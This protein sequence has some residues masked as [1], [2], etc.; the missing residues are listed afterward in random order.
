MNMQKEH[1]EV[2]CAFHPVSSSGYI[3]H[4][5][6]TESKPRSDAGTMYIYIVLC[7]YLT[8][9]DLCNCQPSQGTALSSRGSPSWRTPLWS[10]PPNL[11]PPNPVLHLHNIITLRTLY[12]WDDTVIV[13][14]LLGLAFFH[15]APCPGDHRSY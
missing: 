9:V 2:L 13:C 10:H 8:C 14:D 5:C 3:L 1:R 6:R 7:H 12:K 11:L 15:S 4:N